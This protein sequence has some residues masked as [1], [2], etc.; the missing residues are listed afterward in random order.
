MLFSNATVK[1]CPVPESSYLLP[2]IKI[3]EEISRFCL[4]LFFLIGGEVVL[5]SGAMIC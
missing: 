3:Q 2:T 1:A 5:K 4:F